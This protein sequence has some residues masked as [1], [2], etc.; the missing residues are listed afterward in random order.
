LPEAK[1]LIDG[2][3]PADATVA[4]VGRS[5]SYKS[6]LALDWCYHVRTGFAWHD[7]TTTVSEIVYLCG[8]GAN[9]IA[10][11]SAAW[12]A[13][14]GF[15]GRLGVHYI[16]NTLVLNEPNEVANLVRAIQLEGVTPG[17]VVI[18]TLAKFMV[19]D[20]N[21]AKDMGAFVRGA[22]ELRRR[23]GCTVV[24]IHHTGKDAQKG[25]RGSNSLLCG[26]DTEI[27]CERDGKEMEITVSCTK[28]KDAPEFHPLTLEAVQVANSLALKP[29]KPYGRKLAGKNLACLL[30]LK[31]HDDGTGLKYGE[32]RDRSGEVKGTFDKARTWLRESGYTKV[33]KGRY[34]VSEAGRMAILS[35]RSTSGLLAVPPT[36]G[37]LVYSPGLYIQPGVNQTSKPIPAVASRTEAA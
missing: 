17:L 2:I 25:G 33:E 37:D 8:E 7:R 1:W 19:G 13:L 35:T 20:E 15:T 10:K 11:R 14:N 23:F 28:Q 24:I 22:D 27:L 4:V 9:G 3:L 29:S 21:T 30:A 5:G 16:T 12:K 34:S 32:W 31:E 26:V 6:F 18:D 36:S